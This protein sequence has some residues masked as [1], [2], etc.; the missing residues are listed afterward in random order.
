MVRRGESDSAAEKKD[1]AI[2]E[3]GVDYVQEGATASGAVR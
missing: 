2:A 3:V 1:S